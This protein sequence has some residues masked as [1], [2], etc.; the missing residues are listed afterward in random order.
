MF[1]HLRAAASYGSAA[2][3]LIIK[4]LGDLTLGHDDERGDNM[5]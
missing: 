5:T 2:R 3:A 1:G 4:A